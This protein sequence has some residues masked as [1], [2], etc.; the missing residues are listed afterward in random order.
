M[1]KVAFYK[2][3]PE[4]FIYRILNTAVRWWTH[5][6]YSHVEYIDDHDTDDVNQWDWYSASSFKEKC[7]RVKTVHIKKGHWDIFDLS[8]NNKE[9]AIELFES[10]MGKPYDWIGIFFSQILPTKIH[11]PDKWFCSEIVAK[12]LQCS[13]SLALYKAPSEYS[14]NGL[15]RALL[16]TTMIGTRLEID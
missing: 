4:Q 12:A 3:R 2:G 6:P 15:Y 8:Y 14:P 13:G 16:A 10:Q 1:P 5:G 11:N 7:V 9:K